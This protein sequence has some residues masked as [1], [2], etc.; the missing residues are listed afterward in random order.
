MIP[1]RLNSNHFLVTYPD[2]WRA[3]K[4]GGNRIRTTEAISIYL[5]FIKS[6]DDLFLY[7][8]AKIRS[9]DRQYQ[10]RLQRFQTI[11]S[12]I[13]GTNIFPVN[14]PKSYKNDHSGLNRVPMLEFFGLRC[15]MV[16]LVFCAF[17]TT[18]LAISGSQ[19]SWA[20]T[21]GA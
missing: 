6:A 15:S 7:T 12:P 11:A 14:C 2:F 19:L 3:D 10:G 4:G 5:V 13:C 20:W 1:I 17:Y 9:I 21:F 18:E 16:S 8:E